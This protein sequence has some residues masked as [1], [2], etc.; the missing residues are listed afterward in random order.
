MPEF[1][2]ITLTI[3]FDDD[4]RVLEIFADEHSQLTYI[5]SMSSVS[6]TTTTYSYGEETF[7]GEHYA[8]YES[9]YKPVVGTLESVN[10]GDGGEEEADV[11]TVFMS[12]FE[13]MLNGNGQQFDIAL[14]LGGR[15]YAGRL[16]LCIDLNNLANDILGSVEARLALSADENIDG[17]DLYIQLK[18]AKSAHITA[19]TLR[20]LPISAHSAISSINFP[21]GRI[22]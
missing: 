14:D 3:T 19:A 17:Q 18:E 2:E 9:C 8:L 1:D 4:Y 22:R 7:D 13:G 12:A 11:I 10:G 15:R 20:S 16:F 5:F 6:K 21:H